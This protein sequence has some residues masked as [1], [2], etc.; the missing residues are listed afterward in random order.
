MVKGSGD[1]STILFT[2]FTLIPLNYY[3]MFFKLVGESIGVTHDRTSL[4]RRGE[5]A[6]SDIDHCRHRF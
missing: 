4:A 1:N 6:K 2:R 3:E 5:K